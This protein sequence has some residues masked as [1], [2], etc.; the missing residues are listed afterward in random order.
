MSRLLVAAA[1]CAALGAC[2]TPGGVNTPHANLE[3]AENTAELAYQ[4][5]ASVAS[6]D[7]DKAWA[8]LMEVRKLY[9]TGQDISAAVAVVQA[10]TAKG[11]K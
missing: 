11:A 2:A 4:A 7:K 3:R 9:N 5:C 10:D 8:D 6:C 1:L